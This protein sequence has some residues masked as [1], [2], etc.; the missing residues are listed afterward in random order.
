MADSYDPFA[1]GGFPV[2]VR[3]LELHDA[4]RARTFPCEAWYPANSRYLGLDTAAQTQDAFLCGS[5]PGPRR[6]AAVRDAAA[7]DGR[8][9]LIVFSHSSGLERRRQSTFLCTHLASHGYVVA[10]IDHSEGVAKELQR[11]E[12][13]TAQE[14]AA[15]IEGWISSRVPDVRLV[16]DRFLANDVAGVGALV[17]GSRA[18]IV[19]HSFGGWTALAAPESEPRVGAVVAL[20]PGGASNPPP[21]IIPATLTF[22]WGRDVPTLYLVAEE[23]SA[24]PL[25]GMHELFERTRSSKRMVILRHADHGH[26]MDVFEEASG[27]CAREPAH[28]FTRGLTVAHF[29]AVL[30]DLEPARR[31]WNADVPSVLA[32]RG[33]DAWMPRS[34]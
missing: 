2:G 13:E 9:P 34:P 30:R 14:R 23:D 29:D 12:G 20:A 6:Q 18:G 33:V 15:R 21:G 8:F 1:R 27:L 7:A 26:F 32:R 16:L 24:L 11:R 3:T 22:E 28:L 17:D 10:A 25:A 4:A 19:G 5:D 31:F